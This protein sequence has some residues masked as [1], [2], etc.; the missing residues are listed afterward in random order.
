MPQTGSTTQ[1]VLLLLA[2]MLAFAIAASVAR[3]AGTAS[4][5]VVLGT[6]AGIA[7]LVILTWLIGFL[8]SILPF[9]Q[10]DFWFAKLFA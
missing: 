6:F 10:I 3:K 5:G 9:G 7:V 2:N 8:G 1:V 4:G